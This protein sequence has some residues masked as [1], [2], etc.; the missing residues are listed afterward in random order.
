ME[1]KFQSSVDLF[2]F[3]QLKCG[4]TLQSL[5]IHHDPRPYKWSGY[6]LQPIFDFHIDINQDI[7]SAWN[8]MSGTLRS[9]I[10]RT[11]KHG[12][13][14]HD[15]SEDDL[16]DIYNSLLRRYHEQGKSV[17][18]TQDYLLEL[19]R[20]FSPVN[21]KIFTAKE[22]GEPVSGIIVIL[23]K[24]RALYWIGG[25]KPAVKNFSPN[26]LAQWTAIQYA[27]AHGCTVYEEIGA[28]TERLS[29]FKA[30]YNPRLVSRFS[31]KKYSS[32]YYRVL[33]KGYSTVMKKVIRKLV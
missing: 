20:A 31:V 14:I 7:T 2:L 19:Y 16:I 29:T 28:G 10:R 17:T 26:D 22:D 1:R 9:D 15:G 23:F 3:S 8:K 21:F 30:K 4:Y 27:H 12:I 33:E 11:E 18:I 6:T 24:N 13:S 32:A 5:T 25:A